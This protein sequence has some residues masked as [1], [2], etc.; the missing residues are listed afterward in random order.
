[1]NLVEGGAL[2]PTL[3]SKPLP[4]VTMRTAVVVWRHLAILA[5]LRV[6]IGPCFSLTYLQAG[7]SFSFRE[8]PASLPGTLALLSVATQELVG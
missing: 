6:L 5:P 7:P 8:V 3:H 1:M 4:P 2:G